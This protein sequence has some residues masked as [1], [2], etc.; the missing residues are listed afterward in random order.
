MLAIGVVFN[1]LSG[2]YVAPGIVRYTGWY[3][4]A[5]VWGI[6]IGPFLT[7]LLLARLAR[8]HELTIGLIFALAGSI[9]QLLLT[10]DS[11]PAL[12]F[13]LIYLVQA[14]SVISAAVIVCCANT[15]RAR[16]IS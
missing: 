12:D 11:R 7:G 10:N 13:S 6:L 3:A 15:H 5:I 1:F 8:G 14:I 4:V 16:A 2:V 9:V